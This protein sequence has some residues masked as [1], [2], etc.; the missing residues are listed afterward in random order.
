VI[1][2]G[3][4]DSSL[5]RYTYEPDNDGDE[6]VTAS[7]ALDDLH[8]NAANVKL[9]IGVT[10]GKLVTDDAFLTYFYGELAHE[11]MV[12]LRDDAEVSRASGGTVP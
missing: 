5:A 1:T 6:T 12:K 8:A 11:S 10:H 2:E 9:M 4:H 3:A 7:S